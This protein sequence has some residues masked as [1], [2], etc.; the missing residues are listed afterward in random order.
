MEDERIECRWFTRQELGR[1]IRE[2]KI[3]DGKTMLGVLWWE[4]FGVHRRDAKT[5]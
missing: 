5:L 3:A 2:G 4:R 1:M